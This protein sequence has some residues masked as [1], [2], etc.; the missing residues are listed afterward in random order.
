MSRD[1]LSESASSAQRSGF[2]PGLFPAGAT[3][4]PRTVRPRY[5][6]VVEFASDEQTRARSEQVARCL[7][8][9]CEPDEFPWFVSDV[10]TLHD[11]CV[12]SDEQMVDR[13]ETAFGKRLTPEQLRLPIWKVAD[14]LTS[15]VS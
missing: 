14:L 15:P 5:P 12:L 13:F 6:V 3:Y 7:R 1:G 11:V 9:V 8:V 4:A 2:G 10:A